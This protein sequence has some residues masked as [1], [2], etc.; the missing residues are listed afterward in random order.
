MIL[1]PDEEA[2]PP[3]RLLPWLMPIATGLLV[4]AFVGAI[5]FVPAYQRPAPV[6]AQPAP[7]EAEFRPSFDRASALAARAAADTPDLPAML[8][9]PSTDYRRVTRAALSG[10]TGLDRTFAHPNGREMRYVL[11]DGRDAAL[12]QLPV[13]GG[14]VTPIVVTEIGQPLTVVV[15]LTPAGASVRSVTVR[16]VPATSFRRDL[17]SVLTWTAGAVRYEMRSRTLSADE[18]AQLAERLR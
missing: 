5:A 13:R 10:V 17:W 6:A 2:R 9:L 18:L 7:V 4:S 11:A 3:R 15:G 14:V 1:D 12:A 16:G 8:L